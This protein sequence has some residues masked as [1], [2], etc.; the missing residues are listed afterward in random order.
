MKTLVSKSSKPH[1]KTRTH[2]ADTRWLN[3]R[4]SFIILFG[5][6][7]SNDDVHKVIGKNKRDALTTDAKLLLAMV[8]KVTKVNVEH[9]HTENRLYY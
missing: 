3:L 1:T 7:S 9:L 5:V 2:T 4:N 8:K 6:F